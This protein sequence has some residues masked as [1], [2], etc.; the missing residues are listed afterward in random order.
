MDTPHDTY[1]TNTMKTA[2]ATH[3]APMMDTSTSET[4]AAEG[5]E[6]GSTPPSHP[7]LIARKAGQTAAH[8]V[9]FTPEL[10]CNIISQLPLADI[11]TTTG[12]CHFWRSAVAADLPLQKALFLQPEEVRRVL[13]FQMLW[14][15][16]R[17]AEVFSEYHPGDVIPKA[18]CYTIG[19]IHPFLRRI[20]GLVN[21]YIGNQFA[22]R[23]RKLVND[24]FTPDFRHPDGRWRDMFISQ[25]PCRSIDIT[26]LPGWA[27]GFLHVSGLDNKDG[28]RLG[29]LYDTITSCLAKQM[30]FERPDGYPGAHSRHQ[31]KS[32]C[33]NKRAST[34]AFSHDNDLRILS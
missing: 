33:P 24:G 20:C 11:V 19:E 6:P 12:V 25:P 9:L 1:S 13:V 31:L 26:M 29:E 15:K 23:S 14:G 8:A 21:T 18:W 7:G 28:I 4:Q 27:P 3:T 2:H 5:N 30:S 10:L 22:T 16:R 34:A 17:F 32:N